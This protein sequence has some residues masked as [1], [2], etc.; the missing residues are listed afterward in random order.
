M[1]A[2][3]RAVLVRDSMENLR[4]IVTKVRFH[5]LVTGR[6]IAD[7]QHEGPNGVVYGTVGSYAYS[8][9]EPGD[10]FAIDGEW[11]DSSFKGAGEKMFE[12]R[13]MRPSLPASAEAAIR[14]L[15]W[16]FVGSRETGEKR[17]GV[18]TEAIRKLVQ[19]EGV[20]VIQAAIENPEILAGLAGSQLHRT[21][22]I[23]EWKKRTR[24]AQ[25]VAL[26]ESCSLEGKVIDR[27]VA[28]WKEDTLDNLKTNPYAAAGI[29]SVGF[30]NAEK[31]GGRLNIGTDDSRR[32][33][34]AVGEVLRQRESTGSTCADV[35]LLLA[36]LRDISGIDRPKLLAFVEEAAG[37]PQITG[38][39]FLIHRTKQ[40]PVASPSALLS[41]E[42]GI[43]NGL[44]G[45]IRSGRRN[46]LDAVRREAEALFRSSKEF[47]R[48]DLI[49]RLAVVMAASEPVSIITGGPGTG[50][51]TVMEVVANLADK[52]DK[53]K[54]FLVAPTG[55]ASKRLK[56]T[57][58]RKTSTLHRL[59]KAKGK[60]KGGKQEFLHCKANPLPAGSVVVVDESSMVDC[61][62][63]AALVAA[64]PPD[65]R[66]ILVGDS[67]Q[68]PSVSPGA[69][70]ADLIAARTGSHAAIPSVAL[71]NVYRS[72][73]DGAIALGA[74]DIRNGRTPEI[75]PDG[76][77]GVSFIDATSYSILN[78]IERIVCEL[79]PSR[80]IDPLKDAAV[81]CPQRLGTAGTYELN[82]RLQQRLN[83]NGAKIPGVRA[84]LE[85]DPGMPIPAVGDRVMQTVNDAENDVMNGDVGTIRS[86][87]KNGK[88]NV[89]TVSYDC[90][91]EIEYP[92]S[93]W[94]D[95][96]VAYAG[97]IHR[98]Q[99]SQY[100]AVVMPMCMAH[101]RMLERRL[102]YTGWTR[103][104][105][106]LYLIG[107]R[108]AFDLCVAT[109]KAL[110]QKT[111]LRELVSG[112]S[113]N[114]EMPADWELLA[115]EAAAILSPATPAV[116][117]APRN[118]L[119]RGRMPIR[120]S[121]Q[122]KPDVATPTPN[123]AIRLYSPLGGSGRLGHRP[124]PTT[125]TADRPDA[126]T[127]AA[128]KTS[129]APPVRV[130][131]LGG[132]RKPGLVLPTIISEGERP[133]PQLREALQ[134]TA[135]PVMALRVLGPLGRRVTVRQPLVLPEASGTAL[136]PEEENTPA[137]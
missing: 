25:A 137:M 75:A 29:P 118:P 23:A 16:M 45:L 76:K 6:V 108:Q 98:S 27:I 33:A 97:T 14:Y 83:P 24:G 59:L 35:D 38:G 36:G 90:G 129:L 89:F 54:L 117:M 72:D 96:I 40:G 111:L 65:G 56:E 113:A 131:P 81:L 114:I 32:L 73:K 48:L 88:K 123:T 124:L 34:A 44:S 2:D 43:A 4:G 122:T 74:K 5:D 17:F 12:G 28:L 7:V 47:S 91:V 133:A 62:M 18:S 60:R 9:P 92:A 103:A 49:Q 64:M 50:K 3:F 116:I 68:L 86:C 107:E 57:T 127:S 125:P 99:G 109:S 104:K 41:A 55:K 39:G 102:L 100:K 69:V 1:V 110:D 8:K 30:K 115:E 101:E 93:S 106:E 80:G 51:S 135:A 130:G 10:C 13:F 120:P 53:G 37:N 19:R 15:S 128:L 134:T 63:M 22:I 67:G 84:G 66:L 132:L 82:R 85:D 105:S 26:M 42:I 70:L 78:E 58:G 46:S 87:G 94:R 11:R 95:L 20:G 21:S 112:W 71:Q 121:L 79:L 61:E 119:G 136:V 77:G 126:L 52:F 31:L